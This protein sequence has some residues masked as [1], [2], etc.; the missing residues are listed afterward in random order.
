MRWIRRPLLFLL[1][2]LVLLWL[3]RSAVYRT[4][5]R[6]E[7]VGLRAP[8]GIFNQDA[9][10]ATELDKAMRVALDTTAARL[11]F[12]T[13]KVSNDPQSLIHGGAA[14]C[15]GYTALCAALLKAKL[16]AAGLGEEYTVEA[17]I[18]KLY[19]GEQDLHAF[20]TSSFWKDHD[21]VRV[22]AK[23]SNEVWLLD[24]TLYDVAGIGLVGVPEQ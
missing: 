8:V 11:H 12:S 22:R 3:F 4:L 24:P 9:S 14:N 21:V 13:G 20:F 17:V 19:I 16:E 15:I 6:Y 18:G 2:A 7:V 1:V 5:V 10:G 23:A